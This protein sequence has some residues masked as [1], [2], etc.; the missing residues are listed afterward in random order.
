MVEIENRFYYLKD[1][2]NSA[3]PIFDLSPN[4]DTFLDY[5]LHFDLEGLQSAIRFSLKL[6]TI[7]V[8]E[9]LDFDGARAKIMERAFTIYGL[10]NE[11]SYSDERMKM[12]KRIGLRFVEDYV[13]YIQEKNPYLISIPEDWIEIRSL[14]YGGS[15]TNKRDD[16]DNDKYILITPKEEIYSEKT[17]DYKFHS[18]LGIF[19]GFDFFKKTSKRDKHHM[20]IKSLYKDENNA[21]RDLRR[22]YKER[23]GFN[24]S[25]HSSK[26][27]IKG[28]LKRF[29]QSLV[30]DYKITSLPQDLSFTPNHRISRSLFDYLMRCLNR[31]FEDMTQLIDFDRL[32][33][34]LEIVDS[35]EDYEDAEAL[36]LTKILKQV[37]SDI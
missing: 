21:S 3:I 15:R 20:R 28:F 13:V 7:E 10:L 14:A 30:H 36:Y 18:L 37:I 32:E 19:V 6:S 34:F 22:Y 31:H 24:I 9:K 1:V 23:G 8:M 26:A 2:D 29:E 11:I 35:P 27:S 5:I 4:E 25:N 33:H 16:I 12:A 17:K